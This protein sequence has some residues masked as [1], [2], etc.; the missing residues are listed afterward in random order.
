MRTALHAPAALDRPRSGCS[1]DAH[2]LKRAGC[3]I[4]Y[5]VSLAN[6]V[7]RDAGRL[8]DRREPTSRM[9]SSS[10]EIAVREL[11]EFV[12]RTEVKHLPPIVAQI[13]CGASI[14][15]APVFPV[16]RCQ[17]DLG[18]DVLLQIAKWRPLLQDAK[19]AIAMDRF[20]LGPPSAACIVWHRNKDVERRMSGRRD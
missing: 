10:D 19:N 15:R 6:Q 11:L 1:C 4:R 5:S 18:A 20:L 12:V 13:E 3:R 8:E 7:R 17:N 16:F 2:L 9:G 14:N